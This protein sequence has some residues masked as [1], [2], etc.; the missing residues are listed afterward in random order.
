[1]KNFLSNYFETL[2]FFLGPSV[3]DHLN[4]KTNAKQAEIKFKKLT[5]ILNETGNSINQTEKL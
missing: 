2:Y 3:C 1:M 4:E 5:D